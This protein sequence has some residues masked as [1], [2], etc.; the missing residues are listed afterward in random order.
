[1]EVLYVSPPIS[2]SVC[3]NSRTLDIGKGGCLI[4]PHPL[5]MGEVFGDILQCAQKRRGN[6]EIC[7]WGFVL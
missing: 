5:E 2:D 1:L 3:A 6:W 7:V 4:L